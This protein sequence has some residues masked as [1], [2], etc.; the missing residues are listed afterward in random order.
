MVAIPCNTAHAFV[1]RLVDRS[2][3][4][5]IHMIGEVARSLVL[6]QG[7]SRVGL[8]ATSGTCGT[9]IY[10]EWLGKEGIDVLVPDA[11]TQE[12]TVMGAIRAIKAGDH[13]ARVTA[14]LEGAAAALIQRGAQRVIA[15]CTEIPLVLTPDSLAVPLMDPGRILAL[16]VLAR[17]GYAAVRPREIQPAGV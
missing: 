7:V 13:S 6:E 9:G 5:I 1:P 12:H 15:G 16:A 17:A 10:G 11:A 4:P 14:S 3:I 8:L 2:P